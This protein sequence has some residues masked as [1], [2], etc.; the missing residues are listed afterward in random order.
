ME[1]SGIVHLMNSNNIPHMKKIAVLVSMLLMNELIFAQQERT[2]DFSKISDVT[3]FLNKAQVTREFKT[4]LDAGK[5]DLVVKG[6][7]SQLDPQSI[8][9][10]GKG[11]FTILGIV[12]QQN[13]L[14]EFNTPPALRILRDSLDH[15]QRQILVENSQKEILN[16]EE[17][18]LLSNQKIGGANQ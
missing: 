14:N 12:H 11:S 18:M 15:L 16:K 4:R 13:Y 6:L 2:I 17:Q 8:Q 1:F 10:E 3:V 5:T 7:T 9:V